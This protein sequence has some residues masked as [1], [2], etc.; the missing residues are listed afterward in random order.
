M[1]VHAPN[2]VRHK[3]DGGSSVV[4][5]IRDEFTPPRAGLCFDY[6]GTRLFSIHICQHKQQRSNKAESQQD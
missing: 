6:G 1:R 2:R 5:L 4:K 3:L